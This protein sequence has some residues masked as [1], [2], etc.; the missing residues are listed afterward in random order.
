MTKTIKIWN[1]ISHELSLTSELNVHTGPIHSIE[2]SP[3]GS[4]LVSGGRDE[5]VRLFDLSDGSFL[6]SFP[7]EAS[8]NQVGFS[9]TRYW[10]TVATDSGLKVWDLEC[11]VLV[12]DIPSRSP[13]CLCFSWSR[14]GTILFAGFS[15][16]KIRTWI[17]E[18]N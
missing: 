1:T 14:D 7:A 11:K 8:V 13:S 18:S 5:E 4:L 17:V 2:I 6:F 16:N 12:A 3:D 10:L 9:P 15:D